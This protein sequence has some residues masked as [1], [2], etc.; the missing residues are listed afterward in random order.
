MCP[1]EAFG[2]AG[3]MFGSN[4]STFSVTPQTSSTASFLGG[5]NG[6]G[7]SATTGG[8]SNASPSNAASPTPACPSSDG[9]KFTGS[10]GQVYEIGCGRYITDT[11]VSTTNVSSLVSCIG[12]CDMYNIMSFNSPSPCVGVSFFG[13]LASSNCELKG[14][15]TNVTS[16][17]VDSASLLSRSPG[18]GNATTGTGGTGGNGD[19]GSGSAVGSS[20]GATNAAGSGGP[21]TGA[22]TGPGTGPGTAPGSTVYGVS[23]A[24]STI[25]SNGQSILSTYGVSTALSVIYQPTT[26]T[27]TTTTVSISV[28]ISDR[29]VVTTA[30]GQTVS[31]GGGTDGGVVTITLGGGNFITVTQ[32]VTSYVAPSSS[33]YSFTCRTYAT[34]Y[35]NGMHGRKL[36]K[37]RSVFD[38]YGMGQEGEGPLAPKPGARP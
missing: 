11:T 28:S 4:F 25:V 5:Y 32:V 10:L 19:Y 23:T 13:T 34:N 14:G 24:V 38:K 22:G 36:A 29:T 8:A 21:G 26:R 35:L 20:A 12:A 6:F 16:P 30:P 37:R 2:W 15:Y 1:P 3:S 9:V 7:G 31:V 27:V 17:G 33:S 18:A